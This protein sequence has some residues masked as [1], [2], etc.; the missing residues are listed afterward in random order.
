MRIISYLLEGVPQVGE[1]AGTTIIP[2]DGLSAI[3]PAMTS[4][5]LR[6]ATRLGDAAV[7]LDDVRVIA[8]SPE[9]RKIF[10]VGLNYSDHIGESGRE[11]PTYP[12]L[13]PKWASALIG[14][15][16]PIVLP[17]ESSQVD[18]EG[19]LVVVIGVEG[20]RIAEGDALSHVLGYTIGNDITM[21][22]YQYKTH[23]W[24]QG[25]TWD[26]STPIGPSLVTPDEFDVEHAAISTVLNG[27]TVQ[28]SDLSY[29]MF[30]IPT[31]IATISEFTTLQ[32]GDLI[33][34]GTPGGVGY[35]R[36]PQVFLKPGDTVSVLIDGIGELRSQVVTRTDENLPDPAK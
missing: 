13:F 19:E 26:G 2:L 34:T 16:D 20:R 1:L 27:K 30:S 17:P 31:L 23:Q 12:V 29:L 3:G 7:E 9:P 28:S 5:V 14:P 4:S 10:C 33:F 11:T 18:Y 36:D 25:K 15:D 6:H 22:D 21:R 8:V 24:M 32:P 35:R